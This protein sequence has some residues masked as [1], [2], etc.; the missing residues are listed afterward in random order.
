[1]SVGGYS[2]DRDAE[3]K[4]RHIPYEEW[5]EGDKQAFAGARDDAVMVT[6][7]GS[8]VALVQ[9]AEAFDGELLSVELLDEEGSVLSFL[10]GTWIEA[11][12]LLYLLLW[13]KASIPGV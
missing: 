3:L 4:I 11:D 9:P 7:Q 12:A 5:S 6:G 10:I 13:Q 1:M 8:L 2:V